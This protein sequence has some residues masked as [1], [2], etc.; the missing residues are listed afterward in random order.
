M[1]IKSIP[2]H[3]FQYSEPHDHN[4]IRYINLARVEAEDG[5]VSWGERISQ[6]PE[7]SI[8]VKM[9]IELGYRPLLLGEEPREVERLWHMMLARIWWYGPRGVAGF[10]VSAVDMALWAIK[11]KALCRPVASLIGGWLKEIVSAMASIHFDMEDLDRTVKEFQW[12]RERGYGMVEAWV[13][14]GW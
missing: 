5:T 12:F 4:N 7:S 14:P 3:P 8:A 6:F 11:G 2:A 9:N 13:A 1:K 10:A